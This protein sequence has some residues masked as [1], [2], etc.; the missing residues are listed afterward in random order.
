MYTEGII[1]QCSVV[2]TR[3]CNLRCN[4]CYAKS[5]GYAHND[6]I[7]YDDLKSIVDFCCE[8][9]VKYI[10]FTGGEPLTYPYLVDILKYIKSKSHKILTA[11]ATNGILLKNIGLCRD[12]IESGIGY[13]DISMKGNK[14]AEWCEVT[15]YDGYNEQ[16]QA[17]SNLSSLEID[18]TCSM[19]ITSNN[20]DSIC[21]AVR[22]AKNN[23]AKQFSFTFIIDNDY[24]VDER[25]LVY[26][27]NNNPIKLVSNFIS[28]IDE[29]NSITND[30]WIEY[31][32]PI[33]MYTDDQLQTLRGRLA[34]PCQ[35]HLK[36]AVTFNTKM[37]LLP[38]DMYIYKKMAKFGKDFSSY[39]GFL[40]LI[41]N[42][43]YKETMDEIRRLPSED[44]V[45]C[46]H[47]NIC[48]GGCPVLWKNYSFNALK[49]FK[50]KHRG[51]EL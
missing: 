15:G 6:M 12:L 44:C 38:C 31:S 17:I 39:E 16:C 8:A 34:S 30:W 26:L 45:N 2:L 48:Y 3:G 42:D 14:S 28:K 23:G 4:F 46:K 40:K 37:E 36:N 19:V 1:D 9:E 13:I 10:F 5:A 21:E 18:F 47:I 24:G 20:I 25:D 27:K 29:L 22:K 50:E 33:C 49:E 43:K 41:E 51:K 7:K 32:F 35:I 11:V